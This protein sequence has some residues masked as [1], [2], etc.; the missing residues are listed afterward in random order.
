MYIVHFRIRYTDPLGNIAYYHNAAVSKEAMKVGRR[1]F[2]R[3]T[4]TGFT[5]PYEAECHACTGGLLENNRR[6]VV[7]EII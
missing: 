7:A 4:A 5:S 6:F 3:D 2:V 1:F